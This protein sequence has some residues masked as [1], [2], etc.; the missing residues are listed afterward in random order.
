MPYCTPHT[1]FIKHTEIIA[2]YVTPPFFG[3]FLFSEV[4]VCKL[5][6]V[7]KHEIVLIGSVKDE[8]L[9]K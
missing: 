3:C 2:Q 1:I 4:Y 6:G 7:T 5:M 8:L 9:I